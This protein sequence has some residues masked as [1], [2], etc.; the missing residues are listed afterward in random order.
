MTSMYSAIIDGR[1][2]DFVYKRMSAPYHSRFYINDVHLGDIWN[3]RQRGWS[4]V[5]S[6][7]N[8]GF[9]TKIDGFKTKFDCA[10]YLLRCH[11]IWNE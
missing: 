10:R 2:H 9:C 4:V 3:M 5:S 8:D 7:P 1:V 11:G 6:K